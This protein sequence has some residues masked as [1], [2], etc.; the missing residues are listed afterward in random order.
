[1]QAGKIPRGTFWIGAFCGL[2]L[3]VPLLTLALLPFARRVAVD[4][5]FWHAAVFAGLPALVTAG[6]AARLV[7]ARLAE[8]DRPPTLAAALALG[9]PVMGVAGVGLGV[10]VLVPVGPPDP[11]A[12]LPSLAA[13]AGAG[14][15][16]GA[17]VA[18][19]IG[20]R[21]KRRT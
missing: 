9:L 2:V 8:R 1:M 19:L 14:L 12:W 7:A 5:L 4:A 16:V 15:V 21:Q 11:I 10:L 3:G 6:G 18:L 20:A 13:A 17:A